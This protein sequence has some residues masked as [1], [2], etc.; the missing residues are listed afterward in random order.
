MLDKDFIGL[1]F[2]V[3]SVEKTKKTHQYDVKAF[4]AKEDE[5]RELKQVIIPIEVTCNDD[6][7]NAHVAEEM[8]RLSDVLCQENLDMTD[9]LKNEKPKLKD[10]KVTETESE[11]AERYG[12]DALADLKRDFAM[13][14]GAEDDDHEE[15]SDVDTDVMASLEQDIALQ[16]G[17]T[18][19]FKHVTLPTIEQLESETLSLRLPTVD[20]ETIVKE[21]AANKEVK[22][23][24]NNPGDEVKCEVL[25]ETPEE[26]LEADKESKETK[27]NANSSE[28]VE[29][30]EIKE[31]TITK[32]Y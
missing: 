12:K 32:D 6:K 13:Q 24:E 9:K 1:I 8:I 31:E 20:K 7:M 28:T 10:E 30:V 29:A 5:N 21:E 17:Y 2:S 25:S 16:M 11:Y 22:K 4:Q 18:D 3:F 23:E 27:D 19:V 14:M 26:E 15:Y